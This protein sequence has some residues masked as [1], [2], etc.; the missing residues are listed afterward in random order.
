MLRVLH[1]YLVLI[2]MTCGQPWQNSD[3]SSFYLLQLQNMDGPSICLTFTAPSLMDNLILIKKFIWSSLKYMK[4]RTKN[5]MC[6]NYSNP[7]MD[8]NRQTENGTMPFAE[9]LLISN[10]AVFYAHQDGSITILACHVNNCTITKNS[11]VSIQGYCYEQGTLFP[12]RSL[13]LTDSMRLASC[14]TS[15][16]MHPF[17]FHEASPHVPLSL[18]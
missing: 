12:S 10:P 11:Q 7:C 9:C 3:Q 8:P 1:K 5:C 4:N 16:P 6:V 2:I 15:F 14:Y 13:F 17:F 18:T